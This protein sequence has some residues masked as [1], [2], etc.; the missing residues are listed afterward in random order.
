MA[1]LI[2]VILSPQKT[3]LK[4]K[5]HYLCA[6]FKMWTKLAHI[7]LKFRLSLI[8]ILGIVTVIMA[9]QARDL[10]M[11][12]EF[13]QTVPA[14][15]PDMKQFMDFKSQFGEDGNILAIGMQDSS[16]Y[17]PENFYR[18]SLL[19]NEISRIRGV[20]EVLGMPTLK[21]IEKDTENKKFYIS[22]MFSSIPEHQ[23]EL[24]SMLELVREQ[25]FYAGQIFNEA[26]G[27]TLILVT[28][29]REVLNSARRLQVTND[30]LFLGNE[31]TEKTG[32]D[33][34]YAGLPF[35]RSVVAG[36]IRNEM[37]SFL[38]LSV[39]ISGL[40]L[41]LFFRSWDAVFIP[42]IIIAVVV[43]WSMGTLA[44]FGY[45]ITLLTGLLPPI[46]VVIGIPNSIYLLN[47]YHQEIDKYGNKIRALSVM[48]RKIGIV[49]LIT[50][51]TTAIGFGVLAFTN[52]KILREFGIVASI[53]IMSTFIVSII[54][55]PAVFSYLPAP[56]GKRLKH[57][58]FK[59]ID[60]FLTGVDLLVHQH[61]YSVFV[62]ITV[63][64][65]A[66]IIGLYRV[67]SVSFM[68]D[69]I[70][71]DSQIKKDLSFFEDNFKGIMPLEI[72][73]DT[74]KK[75][76]VI[77]NRNLQ[78]FEALENFLE[79]QE[80]VSKPVSL[81][82]FMK[83]V[84]QAFYNNNPEYYELP[85]RQDQN[86]IM[87]YFKGES[88][89]N[90]FINTFVD[91]TGQVMRIS[92]KMADIGSNKMHELIKDTIQPK[93]AEIF[94]ETD[95]S[96]YTTGTTL[97][98]VKGNNFLIE[99]LRLSLLI[100]FLLI[101]GIMALLFRY[102][103]MIILSLIPNM[104]PILITAGLMGFAGIPFKPS[105]VITF[106]IAFGI[107]V[108][109]SIHFLAK[110]R[111]ELFSNN[112]S[113]PLAVT[114][115]IREIGTSMVYTSLVLFAG[116]IIFAWSNFGGTIALGKLTSITLLIA[117]FTNLILLPALLLAFDDGKRKK[118]THPLIESYNN[119][120]HAEEDEEIKINLIQVEKTKK[121]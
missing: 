67:H 9:Y 2:P 20:E 7:V 89:N 73:V 94:N 54:L 107:S 19:C 82:S 42:M 3:F 87:R 15:D 92:L 97:L 33:L 23:A 61:K 26:N 96:A 99:N 65:T 78:K 69:D 46:I 62:V 95:I 72:V 1:T 29:S 48:I 79:D 91:S 16:L 77:N 49:T 88:T 53:L 114:N 5:N 63:F 76:G 4:C 30:I 71:E 64:V 90:P 85:N 80:Y 21:R 11:S 66:S 18:L 52:I 58:N 102:W 81:V 118:D 70:P 59:L 41:A 37:K 105:T 103:K 100:A 83:A 25:R 112:F 32:I 35:V 43:I 31:Y 108:D 74:G 121:I 12:Y 93:M 36:Q 86:F 101:S 84:R 13:A 98:F 119:L 47:K 50:N 120:N 117:M 10:E 51:L 56:G 24:D 55:I 27:A 22:D 113:V 57:L 14:N 116:F 8:I 40:I 115:S 104:I 34:K 60:R 45:K 110:Y 75:R 38:I 111:Q 106:S 44:L 28:L 39:I 109:F 68:I 17:T 6:R